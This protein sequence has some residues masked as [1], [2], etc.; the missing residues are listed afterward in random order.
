MTRVP[1]RLL[2]RNPELGVALLGEEPEAVAP[3]PARRRGAPTA[4]RD[5]R[6]ARGER[7][8]GDLDASAVVFEG[9]ARLGPEQHAELLLR[10]LPSAVEVD[11]VHLVLGGPVP[12]GGDVRS[13]ARG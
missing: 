8:R 3:G 4:P 6:S 12:D 11:A 13:P 10:E 7:R 5:H 1:R 9:F 2:V